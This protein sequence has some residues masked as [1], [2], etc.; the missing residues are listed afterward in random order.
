MVDGQLIT[1]DHRSTLIDI[2]HRRQVGLVEPEVIEEGAVLAKRIAVVGVIHWALGI[3][4]EEQDATV[5]SALQLL[6]TPAV[7]FFREH[8]SILSR[9]VFDHDLSGNH[10]PWYGTPSV[11]HAGAG[12][13]LSQ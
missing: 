12:S 4:E 1:K 7:G 9:F 2:D 5:E 8:H 11:I 3:A 6:A 10:F 13:P